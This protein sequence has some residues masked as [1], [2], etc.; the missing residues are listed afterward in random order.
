M[1][2]KIDQRVHQFFSRFRS[3][4]AAKKH[5]HALRD[6]PFCPHCGCAGNVAKVKNAKPVPWHYRQCRKHFSAKTNT[7]F[8][9]S[10]LSYHKCW[11]AIL[12]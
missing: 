6:E 5:A 1:L 7:I 12:V 8:A 3:N 10:N 9:R 11:L 4:E 2:S